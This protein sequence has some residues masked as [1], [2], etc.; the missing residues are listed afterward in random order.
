MQYGLMAE[1]LLVDGAHAGDALA[2]GSAIL[3]DRVQCQG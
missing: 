1:V 2:D 3:V